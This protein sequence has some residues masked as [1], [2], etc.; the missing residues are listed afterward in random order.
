MREAL[1]G[2]L[3][4][5]LRGEGDGSPI[6]DPEIKTEDPETLRCYPGNSRPDD[7]VTIPRFA[8]AEG[9]KL[10]ASKPAPKDGEGWRTESESLRTAL[11]ENVFAGFPKAPPI[12]PPLEPTA[13]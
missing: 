13:A 1:Y 12:S 8:A 2:W 6:P 10:V 7:W 5:Q 9:R 3:T 11:V 4:L